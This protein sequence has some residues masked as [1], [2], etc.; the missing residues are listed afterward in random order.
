MLHAPFHR[1]YRSGPQIHRSLGAPNKKR[2]V[3]S[4]SN[5][6]RIEHTVFRSCDS[7]VPCP[8]WEASLEVSFVEGDLRGIGGLSCDG[9]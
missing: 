5:P 2:A 3:N 7:V 8:L 1:R 6:S 9:S 4:G